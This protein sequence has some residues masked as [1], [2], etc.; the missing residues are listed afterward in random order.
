MEN[1]RLALILCGLLGGLQTADSATIDIDAQEDI[2]RINPLVF[3][4]NLH[5]NDESNEKVRA[6]IR[7]IGL[8][9]YRYP[10]AG[11]YYYLQTPGDGWGSLN[12]LL[13]TD[14]K[15]AK[16]YL[17]CFKNVG[18]FA[19]DTRCGLTACVNVEN[20]T[21]AAAVQWVKYAKQQNL[22]IK[23]WCLGNEV[24]YDT[25]LKKPQNYIACI[26]R[27][28]PAMKAVDP[29]I[30]IG[31]DFGNAYE[32]RLGTW[33]DKILP[34]AGRHV[35][36]ID[37][38]WYPGRSNSGKPDWSIIVASPLRIAED[39]RH[40]RKMIQKHLP[41]RDLEVCYLEWDVF[42]N[43]PGRQSLA[44][45]L[46]AADCLGQ[47]NLAEVAV[48]CNYNLQEKMFGLIPGWCEAAGWGGNP[49]NGVTVRPKA[50]AFK[51]WRKYMA[52]H[53]LVET[54]V[55]GCGTFTQSS[56]WHSLINYT[57]KEVPN[58]S[59]YCARD[60]AYMKLTLMVIN[61]KP[62]KPLEAAISLRG[63]TPNVLAKVA[64]LNGPS[65]LAHNDDGKTF[66][67]VI[68]PSPVSV[69]IT[70]SEFNGASPHFNYSFPAYSVTIIELS[71]K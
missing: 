21:L 7:D 23:Y 16:S 38:H 61:K 65:Y 40:F 52:E 18:D 69:K 29:S 20:G 1:A 32:N 48:A 63:F 15:L 49:W 54:R 42:T 17:G 4:V 11:G 19:R 2:V 22:G 70:E 26:E 28:A 67:S 33:A 8:T 68:P 14:H 5:A 3:G 58:L 45:G 39:I 57:G 71:S 46:F 36:F 25:W 60:A 47:F 59:V 27:F 64:T 43:E 24:Y 62:D 31:I 56:N 35:D 9:V 41:D 55:A 6:F 37:V 51:L 30:R 53:A 66:H 12:S 13:G 44:N 50:L 10:D 34:T